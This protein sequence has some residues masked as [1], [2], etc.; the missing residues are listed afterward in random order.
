MALTY[1]VVAN[2]AAEDVWGRT[3][4]NVLDV[5][6]DSSYP[7]GGYVITPSTWG[8]STIFG[9]EITAI[10]GTISASGSFTYWF[11]VVNVKL[12][13]FRSAG[14]TPAGTISAP[15]ITTG[16]N[17]GTT[18]PVYTNSGALTQTTGATGITG[19]QA[20]TFTGTAVA[21]A[22]LVEVSAATSLTGVTIRIRAF[23]N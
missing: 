15:T 14:F 4:T 23:G 8:M 1:A 18:A 22:G 7:S 20:P 12:R 3:R 6:L 5:T 11:D 9:M 21:A 19:V 10:G 17:A 13:V 2:G 16:T